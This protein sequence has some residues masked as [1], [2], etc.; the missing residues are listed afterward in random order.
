MNLRQTLIREIHLYMEKS[1]FFGI[2]T[3]DTEF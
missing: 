3:I 2:D 1:L